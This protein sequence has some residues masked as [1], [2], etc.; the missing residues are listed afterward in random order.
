MKARLIRLTIYAFMLFALSGC[1]FF[2]QGSTTIPSTIDLT[3]SRTIAPTSNPQNSLSTED[4]KVTVFFEENGGTLVVD[5][6]INKDEVVLE[7]TISRVGFIFDGWYLDQEFNNLFDFSQ[8]IDKNLTLY[9]KWSSQPLSIKI[10]IEDWYEVEILLNSGDTLSDLELLLDD[11]LLDLLQGFYLDES[12]TSSLPINTIFTSDLTLYL[13]I[14][15]YVTIT[16]NNIENISIKEYYGNTVLSEDGI[17]Y[18]R[19]FYEASSLLRL[20]YN[21]TT[22]GYELLYNNLNQYFNLNPGEV[23]TSIIAISNFNII[24]ST[25]EFR[26]LIFGYNQ[27][28]ALVKDTSDPYKFEVTDLTD[29]LELAD[30][31]LITSAVI[32]KK[33]YLVST[34][35]SR[36]FYWGI[37]IIDGEEFDILSPRD[38]SSDFELES[39]EYFLQG[40]FIDSFNFNVTYKTNRRYFVIQEA[41]KDYLSDYNTDLLFVD[42]VNLLDN[43]Q[44]IVY[45]AADLNGNYVTITEN[46]HLKGVIQNMIY[47]SLLNLEEDD[48]I[49]KFLEDGTFI[50]SSGQI[51]RIL[52]D[53]ANITNVL[54][55]YLEENEFILEYDG[56]W[57]NSYILTNLGNVY[58]ENGEGYQNIADMLEGAGLSPE[59]LLVFDNKIVLINNGVLYEIYPDYFRT[60]NHYALVPY[61]Y[62]YGLDATFDLLAVNESDFLASGWVDEFGSI[63]ASSQ[64]ITKNITLYPKEAKEEYVRFTVIVKDK[65]FTYVEVVG[66]RF[67]FDDIRNIIPEDYDFDSFE[68]KNTNLGK[69]FILTEDL[70]KGFVFINVEAIPKV[71]VAVYFIDE[72]GNV[73]FVEHLKMLKGRPF[74]SNFYGE[75]YI[76]EGQKIVGYYLDQD[77][78]IDFNVYTVINESRTVYIKVL[79]KEQYTVTFISD[80]FGTVEMELFEGYN[81]L[82]W[83]VVSYIL[84]EFELNEDYAIESFYVDSELQIEYNFMIELTSDITIYVNIVKP[85]S[86]DLYLYVEDMLVSVKSDYSLWTNVSLGKVFEWFKTMEIEY[87]GYEVDIIATD[88]SFTS[89]WNLEQKLDDT[90]TELHI[91]LEKL[92]MIDVTLHLMDTRVDE[93]ITYQFSLVVGDNIL[94]YLMNRYFFDFGALYLSEDMSEEINGWEELY[95]NIDLYAYGNI[96]QDIELTVIFSIDIEPLVINHYTFFENYTQGIVNYLEDYLSISGFIIEIYLDEDYTIP[97]NGY[98]YFDTTIYVKY[99]EIE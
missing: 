51:Y 33:N 97:F 37:N 16:Y 92:D 58:I 40:A 49:V 83:Y 87:Y 11:E 90:I 2:G 61:I 28:N 3:T 71:D 50:T 45:F 29:I 18:S 5:Q 68:V 63:Y 31:E 23:V 91:K 66:T 32:S 38:V 42:A 96:Y 27:Y 41:I 1:D 9:A 7:P 35:K 80:E 64:D 48:L 36:V 13:Q 44:K 67:N 14:D 24:F 19:D 75:G 57:L 78:M 95:E 94:D 86:A 76:D 62:I 22:E 21:L 81:Y 89:L 70:E 77:L 26:T 52:D 82:D 93:W 55:E 98:L 6:I 54:Q 39:G 88:A 15:D 4:S 25:S 10:H 60:I 72:L 30:D 74:I 34:D 12:L 59:D 69:E 73:L 43:Y 53:M 99:I 84:S 20:Y 79:D 65:H 85:F 8:P 56:D 47:D 17:I 46:G